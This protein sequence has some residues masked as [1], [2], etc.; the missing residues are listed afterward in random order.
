VT[1][2]FPWRDSSK[3]TKAASQKEQKRETPWLSLLLLYVLVRGL[4]QVA[5]VPPWQHYDEPT[6]F[7]YAWLIANR[8][9]LPQPEDFDQAMRRQVAVSMLEH[10]FFNALSVSPDL[11]SKDR[12]IWI[13]ISE[14]K[15]PPLYYLLVALPLYFVQHSDVTFQL[16]VARLVSLILLVL[17]VWVASRLM[18]ELVA[19]EHPLRWAVPGMMA[20]LPAYLDLMTAVN[21]DV[22]A[23]AIFSLFL[24]AAV[25]LIVRGVSPYRLV[26]VLGTAALCVWTK[27]TTM[28]AVLVLP[29]SLAW[30][31]IRRPWRKWV[32][33]GFLGGSLLSVGAVFS[34]GDAALWYQGTAQETPTRQ[35]VRQAPLGRQGLAVE[36]SPKEPWRQVAQLLL[37]KDVQALQGQTVTLGAWMWATQPVQARSPMIDDEKQRFWQAVEVGTSPTFHAITATIA[38]DASR[39]EVILQPRPSQAQDKAITVYYDGVVLA[40]GE[41]P[42]DSA[43]LFDDPEAQKGQWAG[44]TFINRVRNGSAETAWPRVRLW[45]EKTLTKYARRSPSQFLASVLDWQR[46][47]W[48]YQTTGT[49]LHQSFWARFG[50]GHFGLPEGWYWGLGVVTVLGAVGTLVGLARLWH[51]D[52]PLAMKRAVNLLAVTGLLVWGNTF[53]RSHPLLGKPFIPDARYA[54]PAIIPTTLALMSGWLALVPQRAKKWAITGLLVSV[55][56]LDVI[57]LTTNIIFYYGK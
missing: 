57:S 56:L 26:W 52:R 54:Y 41:W 30:A 7:E 36:I 39:I 5:I 15:H 4:F 51:S 38:A 33:A 44:Q 1:L 21:N 32:W 8:Q 37:R 48:V 49:T 19:P 43:P 31:F 3:P 40:K 24:W 9:S 11:L 14:L 23:T 47:A 10:D 22:G 13:G 35:E 29:P 55:A 2:N 27:N 17:S 28:V 25:R 46:T 16:Y 34:W 6:H 53:F 12:P 18:A 45:A 42:V 50:W 20:F